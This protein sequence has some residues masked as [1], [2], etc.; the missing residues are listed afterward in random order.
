MS[1]LARANGLVNKIKVTYSC[2]SNMSQITKTQQ[3][4]TSTNSTTHPSNQRNRRVKSTCPLPGKFLYKNVIYKAKT[5]Q[6]RQTLHRCN[7]GHHKTE[8]LQPWTFFHKHK[9][10]IQ[11]LLILVHRAPKRHKHL[12]YNHQGDTK[13]SS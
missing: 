2:T 3:K 6:L 8:N 4:I 12:S 11:Y 5:K 9:L 1:Y 10:L 13:I 7:G